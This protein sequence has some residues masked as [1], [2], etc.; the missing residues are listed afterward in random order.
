MTSISSI[1]SCF[2]VSISPGTAA[3]SA[4][5]LAGHGHMATLVTL[6]QSAATHT[7]QLQGGHHRQYG[8]HRDSG[9]YT[10]PLLLLDIDRIKDN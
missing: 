5:S 10:T 7:A 9:K 2:C 4:E 3:I 8:P 1:S 6:P